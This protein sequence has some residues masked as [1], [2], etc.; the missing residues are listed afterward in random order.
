MSLHEVGRMIERG[1]DDG[2]AGKDVSKHRRLKSEK[3][4]GRRKRTGIQ[5]RR[6]EAPYAWT[7]LRLPRQASAEALARYTAR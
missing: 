1:E 3:R 2:A 6:K 4:E 7:T 5:L